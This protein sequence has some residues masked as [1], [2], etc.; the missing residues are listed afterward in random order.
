M[1]RP[2]V[3]CHMTSSVDGRIKIKRWSP[4][5]VEGSDDKAYEDIHARLDG[6]AW[7][8]GRVTMAGYAEGDPPSAY[9]G[10]PISRETFVAKPN[11]AGY[12]I[13]LDP[14]GK[15]HWGARNDI[16]GDHVVMVLDRGRERTRIFPPCARPAS[17][18]CSAARMRS[19][20]RRSSASLADRFG[21]RRLL[22][23][24]GGRINGS[25]LKAGVVDELSLVVAPA[26][27][28]LIGAPSV[29]DYDGTDDDRTPEGIAL[30]LRSHEVLEGGLVW[31]RYRIETHAA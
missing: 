20:Y 14:H 1:T 15:M 4:R 16:T 12:A 18:T 30:T 19:T 17:R 31:L 7:I 23:E 3:I 11:A 24:G 29:F 21:I 26:V 25:F 27:D 13:G 28:G 22:V 6:D 8:C 2:T 9:D 5:P 10:P